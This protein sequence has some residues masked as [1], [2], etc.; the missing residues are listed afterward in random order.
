MGIKRKNTPNSLR[1]YRR[2]MGYTQSEV[3]FLLDIH[4]R[5]RISRWEQGIC[6]PSAENLLY[7]SI[8]YC[9]LPH[10]LYPDYLKILKQN[11]VMKKQNM[12]DKKVRKKR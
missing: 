3:A 7:M 9:T 6:M 10:E 1:K 5:A 8:L 2:L 12:N 4:C 11:L